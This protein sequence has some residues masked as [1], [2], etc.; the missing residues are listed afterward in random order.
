[1][2]DSGAIEF[3]I[4][5]LFPRY[6][7]TPFSESILGKACEKGLIRIRV[8][9]MRDFAEGKHRVADD[10]PFG[11]SE[12]MVLKPEPIARALEAIPN[13]PQTPTRVILLTPQG[14]PFTQEV[15]GDISRQARVV[16]ICG[17]Y[18]GV[19]ERVARNLVDQ[20][21]SIGDYVLS[22]GEAAAA[23]VVEAV[24]RLVPGVLGNPESPVQDSFAGG[25]LKGPVY[26]RPRE[27]RGWEVPSVL[28]GG[29]HDQIERWRRKEALRRT[30]DR[31]PDLWEKVVL[32]E[33]DRE[34]LAE[35]DSEDEDGGGNHESH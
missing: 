13:D 7:D 34:L 23:V 33:S 4:L 6:F 31:R 32:T 22:G 24:S 29:D 1:M 28:F 21:L 18:E 2:G 19:D 12:G 14:A 5:T 9:D 25:L 15:A 35:I 10:Y 20:E 16:L 26:T 8:M 17:H 30:R 11:G 3:F 27:F